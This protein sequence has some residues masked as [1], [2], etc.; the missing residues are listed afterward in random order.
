MPTLYPQQDSFVRGEISPR[1]HA[2]ASLDLYRTALSL[3]ENFLTLPHGGL[4]ARGGTYFAGEVKNSARET[5]LIPFIFSAEQAYALEVGHLYIRVYAYGSRVGTVEVV[6]PWVE[7]DLHELQFIQSAD[8]MWIVHSDYPPQILTREGP[9]T[10]TLT[11]AVFNDGPYLPLNITATTMTPADRAS[12]TPLM[13]SNSAPSGTASSSN[14]SANAFQVFDGDPGTDLQIVAVP[15]WIQYRQAGSAQIVVDSYWITAVDGTIVNR[16]PTSWKVEGSNNGVTWTTLDTRK[17][18]SGW[19]GGETR[20]Y[21]FQNK[22]AFEYH[23]FSYTGLDGSVGTFQ[24]AELGFNKAAVSQTAFNLTAS[25][26]TGINDGV[27]FRTTDVGRTIRLLGSDGN[28]RWARIISRTSATVVTIELNGHALPDLSPIINWR[29]S[30]FLPDEQVES[31]AFFEE[32]LAYS[33][34]FSV[35]ASKTGAFDDFSAGE[36]DDDALVFE[37][38]GG[39]QANDIVWLADADGFLLIA[40]S[41]GVRALSGSGLDEALTPT[42]FKNRR[43]RTHGCA[44]IRPIDAGQSFMYVTRSRRA[45]A[46]LVQNASGRFTSE[47]IGQISEHIPKKGVVEIA[48][49]DDPDPIVWFP[50]DNGEMGGYTHQPSQ[51]VRGMH[52]HR[53]GGAFAGS[54]WPIVERA[55]VTPGQDG[56]PNDVWMIVKRTIGGVTKRYIEVMQPAFE[57][58]GVG[59]CFQVDCGLTYSGAPTNSISGLSHL[60]GQSVDVLYT[61]GIGGAGWIIAK[62]RTVSGGAVTLPGGALC[63]EAHVGLPFTSKAETLELDV[64]GQDGS[65]S[66]RRKKVSAIILSL[67]ETDITGLEIQSMQRGAWETVSIPS[68]APAPEYVELFTGNVKVPIDDSWEGMAKVR[69]RFTNPTPCTIRAATLIFDAEP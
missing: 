53:V 50:L 60:N 39:G 20:F 28:W 27:G 66:G 25:S 24:V 46:E 67:F 9:T 36:K 57:Y 41:G 8:Q 26:V 16:T 65:R 19:Y 34:R 56:M 32:R 21:E 54:G 29:M 6:T 38:A 1:L 33:K 15:G 52:R 58:A 13:T 7:A 42:S 3:C 40:T 44:K 48:Y 47:D 49:Q 55:I 63:N 61:T 17:G 11:E 23:R 31:V 69:I 5:I 30:A 62:G 64:G 59:D 10:W 12:L 22:V 51:E 14:A 2:R 18:E 45:I 35:Y 4:R 37:N 43:S 68:N